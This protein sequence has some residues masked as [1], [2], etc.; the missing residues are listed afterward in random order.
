MVG[1]GPIGTR[2]AAQ[3]ESM[4][5]DVCLIDFSSVNLHPL[6]QAGFR[7]VAGDASDVTIL[8]M[9]EVDDSFV[10][11][12]C[13]PDDRMA[14]QIVRAIRKI[15]RD[16]KLIVR[17]RYQF[18]MNKLKSL[19]ADSIIVEETEATL[20]LLRTLGKFESFNESTV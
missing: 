20:A 8:E 18:S 14:H 16:G 7:T 9:A 1:A 3:L 6:T 11:V 15:N 4:G 5:K 17:C 12:V 13:I 10:I 2:I 19:G